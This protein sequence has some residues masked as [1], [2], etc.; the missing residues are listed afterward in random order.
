M[1]ALNS[2]SLATQHGL[3]DPNFMEFFESTR[4][5]ENKGLFI[6]PYLTSRLVAKV[7][8][9]CDVIFSPNESRTLW[10]NPELSFYGYC[11]A[12]SFKQSVGN[13]VQINQRNQILFDWQPSNLHNWVNTVNLF[14]LLDL[15]TSILD[16]GPQLYLEGPQITDFSFGFPRGGRYAIKVK[17][18]YVN[19]IYLPGGIVDQTSQPVPDP[20]L[21]RAT[22]PIPYKDQGDPNT[23]TS[24]PYRPGDE[25][26]GESEPTTNPNL[27]PDNGRYNIVWSTNWDTGLG[28][29]AGSY[30]NV[31]AS[32]GPLVGPVEQLDGPNFAGPGGAITWS[33]IDAEGSK[34]LFA[35]Q[36]S[37]NPAV[38]AQQRDNFTF[39]LVRL[40]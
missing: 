22:N 32:G 4:V 37:T 40:P 5:F 2:F 38:F 36:A 10:S 27:P 33:A 24:P 28:G 12:R 17:I 18:W 3:A 26:F 23:F 11:H 29:E 25:D 14:N 30:D 6:V 20:G 39:E 7:T 34:T 13:P 15:A 31:T 21:V 9:E 1:T 8:C 19:P 16:P 35:V